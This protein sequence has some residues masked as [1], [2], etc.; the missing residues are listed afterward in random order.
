VKIYINDPSEGWIVDRFRNEWYAHNNNISTKNK[1]D[2]D[3][4]WMIANW[5]WREIPLDI[6]T[7]KTVACTIHHIAMQKFNQEQYDEFMARDRYVDFYHVPCENTKNQI[8]QF[9]NKPIYSIPFWV[10]TSNWYDIPEREQLRK[11]FKIDSDKMIIGSFQRDT[12]GQSIKNETYLPKLE[13]GPDLFCDIVENYNTYFDNVEV[14]LAGYRRQ[15]VMNR[16][17]LAGIKYHYFEKPDIQTV[18]KLYNCLDLYVVSARY[19][20]GPQAILECSTNKTPIISTAV[21]V[22]PEILSNESIFN[23]GEELEV[24]PNIEFAHNKVKDL[25]MPLGFDK[26]IEMFREESNV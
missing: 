12:E 10:N 3:I 14:L 4:F 16:L 25:W 8:S 17:N 23:I 22:A 5:K 6:L 19:E 24:S 9:T 20:G 11:E 21:G 26:F 15:Y 18:N 13:K 7:N 1:Y 2:A